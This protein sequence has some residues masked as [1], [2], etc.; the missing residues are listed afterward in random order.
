MYFGQIFAVKV[1]VKALDRKKFGSNL[2][3]A[4]LDVMKYKLLLL[5][6]ALPVHLFSQ[7]NE[8][9]GDSL[10]KIGRS[11]QNVMNAD[12]AIYYF[13]LSEKAFKKEGKLRELYK[14]KTSKAWQFYAYGKFDRSIQ[15]L[16]T[17]ISEGEEHITPL[18]L[19]IAIRVKADVYT[20]IGEYEKAANAIELA[21]EKIGDS[22][23][24]QVL[25]AKVGAIQA[26]GNLRT[27]QALYSEAVEAYER[28]LVIS[29]K[30]PRKQNT[31]Y[32]LYHNIGQNLIRIGKLS[33][34]LEYERKAEKSTKELLDEPEF[35]LVIV[36]DGIGQIYRQLGRHSQALS[37]LNR[38]RTIR[39]AN[40]HQ[41][42]DL[43]ATLITLGQ[44]HQDLGEYD[45]ADTYYQEALEIALNSFG[46]YSLK[47]GD[48]HTS[49]ASLAAQKGETESAYNLYK[50]A[51]NIYAKS[52]EKE[53]D[54]QINTLYR[55][56][57]FQLSQGNT[58]GFENLK[59]AARLSHKFSGGKGSVTS[60]Y[61]TSLA[62]NYL[63]YN[64]MDSAIY[65]FDLAMTSNSNPGS[66]MSE[67][68]PDFESNVLH[69]A[70]YFQALIGKA[71]ALQIKYEES[72]N[73]SSLK[74][75]FVNIQKANGLTDAILQSPQN[76]AD[77][78][79]HRPL[80]SQAFRQG[81]TVAYNLFEET[82]DPNYLIQAF[83]FGEKNKS[84][85]I[86]YS[87]NEREATIKF[88][89]SDSLINLERDLHMG[90]SYYKTE[91]AKLRLA[92]SP[93]Q[94]L[95][96]NYNLKIFE[97]NNELEALI[98]QFESNFS[99]YY[100]AKYSDEFISIEEAQRSITDPNDLVIHY[101]L[102]NSNLYLFM[103]SESG[104]KAEKRVLDDSLLTEIRVYIDLLTD[105]NRSGSDPTELLQGSITLA[106]KL[107]PDS[108]LLAQYS[109]LIII[110]DG[111]LATLPFETLILEETQESPGFSS[112][113]Y[114]IRTHNVQYA[115]SLT[116]LSRQQN[117]S[118]TSRIGEVLAF[119]PVFEEDGLKSYRDQDTVRQGLGILAY[120]TTEVE[121]IEEHFETRVLKGQEA[122]E[123][124][125]RQ[126]SPDYS[127]VHIASH[128]LV[129]QEDPM[130]SK[131]VFS[132]YGKD[133]IN[134]GFLN[135]H[136][137]LNLNI[138]ADMVVLSA[139]NTGSGEIISGEGVL[140]LASSFFYSGAKSLAMSLW[141]AN[142][143][144]TS[145]IMGTFYENLALK[146]SKSSALREAKLKYLEES[147]D[148]R[149]HPYYWAHMIVN[150]NNEPITRPIDYKTYLLITLVLVAALIVVKRR[151]IVSIRVTN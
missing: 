7:Q 95:I 86:R 4:T 89:V 145:D 90:I 69:P 107:L 45:L 110:P 125:F 13:N 78:L 42:V 128:G 54:G 130:Y 74:E 49:L 9:S 15:I 32:Q 6:L 67:D 63:D 138:D 27:R 133:S 114:L 57:D 3:K 136:E 98:D 139:C 73:F 146:R 83:T 123:R 65:Y 91:V 81:L 129:D 149:S 21:V 119:A 124:N 76:S 77:R 151:K 144:S 140:G 34:A 120:T 135:S 50:T 51:L 93:D 97:L 85:L 58:E 60:H 33:K 17:V 113:P 23:D 88:G 47:S 147:D 40:A 142:D 87:L 22:E 30:L 37:Y 11:Y 148:I 134:D 137:V 46:Y 126:L 59:E 8:I 75:A 150:G 108:E 52:G 103:I 25:R 131:L 43:F 104:F 116:V 56:G 28:A 141:T 109:D 10:Y 71:K 102:S 31:S 127:I 105:P 55:L 18:D 16:D 92:D 106:R 5:M 117:P 1:P 36:Y 35:N 14:S 26:L 41:N 96:D 12:S 132:P 115:N 48:A 84:N 24:P 99:E 112:L 82:N 68:D 122:T 61:Y 39:R 53:S 66:V 38:A 94:K 64:S 100:E 118:T 111:I 44:T 101:S 79:M 143:K 2:S 70:D 121:S 62:D 20:W 29:E 80:I 19:G 72:G